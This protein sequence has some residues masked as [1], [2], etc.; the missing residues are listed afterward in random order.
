MDSRTRT[1]HG[2]TRIALATV[3]GMAVL[4]AGAVVAYAQGRHREAAGRRHRPPFL[5]P[6]LPDPLFTVATPRTHP[7]LRRDRLHPGRDRQRRQQRVPGR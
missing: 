2:W 4:V 1:R 7:R 3:L 6:T 5:T